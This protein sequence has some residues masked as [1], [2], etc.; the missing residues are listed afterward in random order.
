MLKKTIAPLLVGAVLLF[1]VVPSKALAQ[2]V[3][4]PE[5]A[6]GEQA[7][8]VA[9]VGQKPELK[10]AFTRVM[11]DADA[12]SLTAADYARIEKERRD[13][14]SKQASRQGWTKREKIG[15]IVGGLVVLA[16][17]VGLL[18][19]G[20]ADEPPFCFEAPENPDCRP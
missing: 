3:A 15:L 6:E 11:S 13:Q 18:I 7:L 16:V 17:V 2:A 5:A 19:E 10:A 20:V 8:S 1:T 14:Q 4:R 9:Q 12:H